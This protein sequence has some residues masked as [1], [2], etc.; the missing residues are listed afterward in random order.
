MYPHTILGRFFFFFFII[1]LQISLGSQQ[2]RH[3]ERLLLSGLRLLLHLPVLPEEASCLVLVL[4]VP[5]GTLPPHSEHVHPLAPI[6]PDSIFSQPSDPAP[7]SL[8]SPSQSLYGYI[9]GPQ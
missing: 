4:S 9:T 6:F 3:V 5:L 8:L 2:Y 7:A 1:S